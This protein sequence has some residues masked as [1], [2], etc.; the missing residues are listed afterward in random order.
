M[1]S[2]SKNSQ[3]KLTQKVT[4]ILA[5]CLSITACGTGTLGEDPSAAIDI[6]QT[7]IPLGKSSEASPVASVTGNVM[8]TSS[9]DQN[10]SNASLVDL[11]TGLATL[12]TD[13]TTLIS[14][15]KGRC[16]NF[17]FDERIYTH[18]GETIYPTPRI[19]CNERIYTIQPVPIP[20]PHPLPCPVT[21]FGE[22]YA[23]GE[24]CG[25][26]V[27]VPQPLPNPTMPIYKHQVM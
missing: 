17:L 26:R 21:R 19:I 11:Q 20:E 14:D 6:P 10:Q 16:E 4:L 23:P 18:Q 22:V 15:M 13:A 8:S 1:K 25:G 9:P 3:I 5:L 7:L 2:I 12:P 24:N 27:V